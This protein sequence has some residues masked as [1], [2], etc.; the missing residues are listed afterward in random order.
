MDVRGD[1][2]P[3]VGGLS[4][5]RAKLHRR[6]GLRCQRLHSISRGDGTTD[7]QGRLRIDRQRAGDELHHTFGGI[8]ALLFMVWLSV[9]NHK[10]HNG[11]ERATPP[12]KETTI[13]SF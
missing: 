6:S 3:A 8:Y 12:P 1:G 2:T 11:P 10:I 4:G 9:L 5:H 13:D 7:Q